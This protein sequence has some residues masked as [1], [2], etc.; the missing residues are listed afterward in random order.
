MTKYIP[1]ILLGVGL[2][3]LAQLLL[4]KGITSVGQFAFTAEAILRVA[5]A[6][7]LNPFIVAGLT[8]YVVSVVIWLLV[9]SRVDVSAA[10]PFLS[11]GY[12]IAAVGGWLW[13]A[14]ELSPQRLLGIALICVG[15][16]FV[17]RT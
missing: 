5:P 3:A 11:V 10:Y 8:S 15:V 2:N 4:K 1:I 9:L 7:A 16:V 6:V 17:A 14:E 12:V 13:F